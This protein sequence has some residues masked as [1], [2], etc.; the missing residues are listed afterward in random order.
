MIKYF[1]VAEGANVDGLSVMWLLRY[2]E[3]KNGLPHS[4]DTTC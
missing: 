4:N 2:G 3:V 1:E